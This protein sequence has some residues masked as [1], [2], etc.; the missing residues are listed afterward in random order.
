MQRAPVEAVLWAGFDELGNRNERPGA[1]RLISHVGRRFPGAVEKHLF[2]KVTGRCGKG[3]KGSAGLF[4]L[5]HKGFYSGRR[6]QAQAS[7]P[8]DSE[9][10]RVEVTEE[11]RI[12]GLGF[13]VGTAAAREGDLV[14][15]NPKGLRCPCYSPSPKKALPIFRGRFHK[16][17]QPG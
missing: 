7:S 8:A 6:E 2:E 14:V 17:S 4:G 13:G 3:R 15:S 9:P 11:F 5:V 12:G 16:R 1:R 10:E